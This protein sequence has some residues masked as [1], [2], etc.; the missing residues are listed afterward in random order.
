MDKPREFW[1]LV[2]EQDDILFTKPSR[3]KNAEKYIHVL[4]AT[5]LTKN[6]HKM[7]EA[8]KAIYEFPDE[9]NID[10]ETWNLVKDALKAVEGK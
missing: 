3:I 7:Y 1:I 10:A 8:L 2:G 4:E 6:A 5:P 9:R